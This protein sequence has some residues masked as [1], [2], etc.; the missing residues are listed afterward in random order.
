MLFISENAE[1]EPT[2]SKTKT[3]GVPNNMADKPVKKIGLGDVVSEVTIGVSAAIADP[4]NDVL[5]R[6]EDLATPE[7]SLTN[8]IRDMKTEVD[9]E[10]K[11]MKKDLDLKELEE[12]VQVATFI[13]TVDAES[14][15]EEIEHLMIE[16]DSIGPVMCSLNSANLMPYDCKSI[17][18]AP[19]QSE[20][21]EIPEIKD[22]F[23]STIFSDPPVFDKK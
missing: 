15:C 2:P 6:S 14:D 19:S 7:S 5:I 20:E 4:E 1:V 9:L 22:D 18:P 8:L 10:K 21:F 12:P 13:E 3:N 11:I 16:E 17:S 23:I